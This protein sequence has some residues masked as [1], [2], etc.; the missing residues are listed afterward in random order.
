M[1]C[2]G[3]EKKEKEMKGSMKAGSKSGDGKK[4]GK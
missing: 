4:K 1:A 2:S 3:K